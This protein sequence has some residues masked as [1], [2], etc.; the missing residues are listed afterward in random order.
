M[1]ALAIGFRAQGERP[2]AFREEAAARARVPHAFMPT[3]R[4]AKPRAAQFPGF[5]AKV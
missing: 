3:R 2:K 4:R 5:A 1:T